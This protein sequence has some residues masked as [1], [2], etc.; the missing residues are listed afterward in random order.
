MYHVALSHAGEQREYVAE[1]AKLLSERNVRCFYDKDEEINLWGKNIPDALKDIYAGK[2]AHFVVVFISAEYAEK[3]FPKFELEH[4]LSHAIQQNQ[5][6]ILPV[7]F[8]STDVPGL[9]STT[10]YIDLKDKNPADLSK[11]IIQK[12]TGMGIYLGPGT[13]DTTAEWSKCP[14]AN[15]DEITIS[16]KDASGN[17]ISGANIYLIHQNGTHHPSQS[18]Q[19]GTAKFRIDQTNKNFHT[20]FIAH[21][22]FPACI[23]DNLLCDADLDITLKRRNNISS[24]IITGTGYIPGIKGRLNPILD[25]SNRTYLYAGNIS[26]NNGSP[27]PTYFKFGENISIVDCF[28]KSADVKIHRIIQQCAI[29]DYIAL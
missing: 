20:I 17:C 1:V 4:A 15:E 27:Q 8:D 26:I 29:L 14:K 16:V 12:I 2:K 25:S 5:E 13:Q 21:D 3:A 22:D 7:R 18:N 9:P 6:Y 11:M 10:T 19:T 28:G 23:I 24:M